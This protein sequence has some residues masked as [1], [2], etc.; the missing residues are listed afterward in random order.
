MRDHHLPPEKRERRWDAALLEALRDQ[1]PILW[2]AQ[3]TPGHPPEPADHRAPL[4]NGDRPA[5]LRRA[6]AWADP[7]PRDHH[8][9]RF[10]KS[11]DNFRGPRRRPAAYH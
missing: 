9:S 11:Q 3:P 1:P 7:A 8:F 4:A 6:G 10:A 5:W 2:S